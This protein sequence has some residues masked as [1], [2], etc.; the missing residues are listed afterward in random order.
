MLALSLYR[1]GLCP[2]CRGDMHETTAI[3]NDEG[4]RA[5]PPIRC[6]RCAELARSAE[7]YQNEPLPQS[8]LHQ[9]ELKPRR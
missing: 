2:T 7:R 6:H 9:V 3:E 8:L 1:D 5:L 4:Y